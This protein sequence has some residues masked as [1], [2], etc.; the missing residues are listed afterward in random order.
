V[1]PRL[2]PHGDQSLKV[3]LAIGALTVSYAILAACST[4][5]VQH[6]YSFPKPA[7]AQVTSVLGTAQRAYKGVRTPLTA[8]AE[9]LPG[10]QV[11]VGATS[12]VELSFHGVQLHLGPSSSL[13]VLQATRLTPGWQLQVVVS[14]S[15]H[16]SVTKD[17]RLTIYA[18]HTT[19]T[20]STVTSF[21]SDSGSDNQTL[22]LKVASGSVS[23]AGLGGK[24]IVRAGQTALVAA[25]TPDQP[26]P[27][28]VVVS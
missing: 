26:R 4:S 12:A 17:T 14:G 18:S 19:V 28:P 15:C 24:A 8:G 6:V 1:K 21:D 25:P 16:V 3:G 7:A 13:Y 22:T 23:V 27:V 9:V 11:E 20:A 5:S 2:A 10:D